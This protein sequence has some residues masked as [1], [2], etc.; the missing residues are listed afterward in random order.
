M[1]FPT[2][3]L[4]YRAQELDRLREINKEL[5]E[6]FS[7]YWKSQCGDPRCGDPRCV[8]ARAAISKATEELK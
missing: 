8:E 6:A 2:Q 5:L 7:K 4:A 1:S 3:S